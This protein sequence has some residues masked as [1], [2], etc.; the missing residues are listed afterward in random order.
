[1]DFLLA[2]LVAFQAAEQPQLSPRYFFEQRNRTVASGFTSIG[3]FER[4]ELR[5][6]LKNIKDVRSY[7]NLR[8]TEAKTDTGVDLIRRPK[9]KEA[10]FGTTNRPIFET[11]TQYES[12]SGKV[13]IE[14][15]FDKTPRTATKV[16][17]RGSLDVLMGGKPADI[18]FANIS[19]LQG[20]TLQ[21]KKFTA[22]GMTIKVKKAR[23]KNKVELIA[24]GNNSILSDITVV[25][26][27][28]KKISSRTISYSY[29]GT[30]DK[31][32]YRITSSQKIPA[33]AKLRVIIIQGGRIH[34]LPIRLKNYNLP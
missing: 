26:N 19:K 21:N 15:L 4:L 27:A 25:D 24:S 9:D 11:P 10:F 7:G 29:K 28:G 32:F 22:A 30:S 31:C 6:E 33:D 1:M 16:T 34:T 12:R 8:I 18:D 13:W 2:L 14:V 3:G 23:Y 5:L 17:I 20:T